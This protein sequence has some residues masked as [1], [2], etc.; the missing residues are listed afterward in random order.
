M[1][2]NGTYNLNDFHS[3]DI[4]SHRECAVTAIKSDFHTI[5][6]YLFTGNKYDESYASWKSRISYQHLVIKIT[7]AF[8]IRCSMVQSAT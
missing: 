1:K 8:N 3:R 7:E 6:F 4:C 2:K 5:V